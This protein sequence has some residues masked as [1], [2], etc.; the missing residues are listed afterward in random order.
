MNVRWVRKEDSKLQGH[1]KGAEVESSED[2]PKFK[3]M[4]VVEVTVLNY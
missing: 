3:M 1:N 4:V 2:Y